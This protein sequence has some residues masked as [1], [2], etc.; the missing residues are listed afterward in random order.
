M[1]RF[2]SC[3][4]LTCCLR[5]PSVSC[6]LWN[7]PPPHP[8]FPTPFCSSPRAVHSGSPLTPESWLPFHVHI[9]SLQYTPW[10]SGQF[11]V[12]HH[13]QSHMCKLSIPATVHS[14][15]PLSLDIWLPTAASPTTGSKPNSVESPLLAPHWGKL[16]PGPHPLVLL[17]APQPSGSLR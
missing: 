14:D 8:P 9:P 17:R 5:H 3:P 11:P 15:W 6:S 10:A 2:R 16:P 7:T 1:N 13:S 12:S 4:G